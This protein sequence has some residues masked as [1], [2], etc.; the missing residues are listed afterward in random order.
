MNKVLIIGAGG[1]GSVVAHKCAMNNDVFGEIM[2]ASRTKAKCDKIAAEIREMHGVEI[3]TAQVDADIVA[4]TVIL[5]KQFQPKM[6]I[7]VA[8]PYQDLTLMEACLATGIHYLD[9][10]N[11]EPKDVAKF[12]YSWQWAYQERFKEAGLM[13]LLGCGFDPGVTQ[14]FT[15]YANKHYF[16]EMHYLDIIDCNAGDHGKAF[17]TNFNPEINIREITQPGRYWENGEWVEIEAMSI[18]KPI[19]YPGIGP[20]ESYVLYHEELESL[21]K[22]FPTLKRARFWMTFGQAYITHLNVLENVGMTSIAPINFKGIDIV[23]LEF[24]KAV[25]PAPDTLGENYSGQTSIGCQ[26]KGIQNGEEKTYYVWNNCDHAETY[27]EVRGQAV[28][29]TTGVPAMIGAML[30]LTNPEWMQP[31]VWNTEQLNPDPFMEKLNEHGLP[32]HEKVNVELP[33]E[34]PA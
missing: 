25:L 3:K 23:P 22:H 8:L 20:K 10:A 24:L 27:R 16:D 19:D 30:M 2:L 28:S 34:Y 15:A 9:T 18:H 31:G 26:I 29:Y 33:H 5:I 13:A 4:E 32:W 11:Y 17:A 1:V 6:L 12:E 21:V 14:V 7:N